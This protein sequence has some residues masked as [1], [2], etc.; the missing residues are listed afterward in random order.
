MRELDKN[1]TLLKV[2][3]ASERRR[4]ESSQNFLHFV[5]SRFSASR[6]FVW[7]RHYFQPSA[8]KRAS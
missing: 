4:A 3:Q 6:I 2:L 1:F 8:E 7:E 5:D